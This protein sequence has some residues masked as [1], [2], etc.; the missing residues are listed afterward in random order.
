[1]YASSSIVKKYRQMREKK[2]ED[3]YGIRGDYGGGTDAV[4]SLRDFAADNGASLAKDPIIRTRMNEAGSTV[5]EGARRGAEDYSRATGEGAGSSSGA[6]QRTLALTLGSKAGASASNDVLTDERTQ[7]LRTLGALADTET[8]RLGMEL[9][10]ESEFQRLDEAKRNRR[11][12]LNRDK[13]PYRGT[14]GQLQLMDYDNRHHSTG[15][16][17]GPSQ[18]RA[19]TA[20]MKNLGLI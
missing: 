1:M 13:M 6:A 16:G 18:G 12:Q 4:K 11:Y 5:L 14:A 7:K 19:Y 3:P 8:T 17:G 2:R 9:A 10:S 15:Y 20:I